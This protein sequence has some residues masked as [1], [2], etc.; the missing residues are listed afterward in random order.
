MNTNSTH[1]QASQKKDCILCK[2]TGS[3]GLLAISGYLFSNSIKI[4]NKFNK[5]FVNVIATGIRYLNFLSVL[6]FQ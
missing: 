2:I 1:S 4:T 6:H 3:C 5:N